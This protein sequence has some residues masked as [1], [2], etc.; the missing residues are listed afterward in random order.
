M[1]ELEAKVIEIDRSTESIGH[2]IEVQSL[3]GDLFQAVNQQV[4]FGSTC[5]PVVCNPQM[6]T[7]LLFTY[8]HWICDEG[9]RVPM[10]VKILLAS[11]AGATLVRA[12]LPYAHSESFSVK[13]LLGITDFQGVCFAWTQPQGDSKGFRVK[14][15][16][17][18]PIYFAFYEETKSGKK[19]DCVHC[20]PSRSNYGRER[21]FWVPEEGSS[22]T[23]IVCAPLDAYQSRVARLAYTFGLKAE[24]TPWQFAHREVSFTPSLWVNLGELF[25]ISF[26]GDCAYHLSIQG[27]KG[28]G[29]MMTQTPHDLNIHH[30]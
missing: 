6:D 23:A 8:C 19:L 28:K 26:K 3:G 30:L 25:E 27:P 18:A 4:P 11:G 10:D 24:G 21:V 12:T 15:R 7:H 2:S 20:S 1:N 14:N 16:R 29:W 17:L 5:T 13:N 22:V 9:L